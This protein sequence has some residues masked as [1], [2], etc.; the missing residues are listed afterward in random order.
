MTFHLLW[1]NVVTLEPLFVSVS[2]SII[3]AVG[4]LAIASMTH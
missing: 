4:C 2:I 1:K 3:V